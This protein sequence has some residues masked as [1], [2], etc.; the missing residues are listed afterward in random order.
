[1]P[2]ECDPDDE[3]NHTIDDNERGLKD[4]IRVNPNEI[5]EIAYP[6]GAAGPAQWR[7]HGSSQRAPRRH[8]LGRPRSCDGRRGVP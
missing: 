8:H 2:S 1:M 5:V 7:F 6:S 3:L 4:T